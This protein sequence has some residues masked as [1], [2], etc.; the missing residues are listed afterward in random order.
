MRYALLLLF[1]CLVGL[2]LVRAQEYSFISYSLTEGLPQSQVSA[3]VEDDKGYLWVGT[4]GGLARFNGSEFV[5]FSTEDGLK[6]NRITSLNFAEKTLWIG[7]EGG[8]SQYRAGKFKNWNLKKEHK[9]VPVSAVCKWKDMYL[10]TTNGAGLYLLTASG[11]LSW[12]N[13]QTADENRIR[14]ILTHQ[15]KVYLAT[16]GGI[17]KTN[18]LKTFYP[19]TYKQ[20][21]INASSI[22]LNNNKL[23]IG[24]YNF[25]VVYYDFEKNAYSTVQKID[26]ESG[27]RNAVID[28]NGN[29]WAIGFDGLIRVSKRGEIK[30]ITE[31]NGL[32]LNSLSTVY[33]DNTGTIWLGSEGKGLF[34]LTGDKFLSYTINQGIPSE[35]I[36]AIYPIN[37]HE[38]LIGTYDKGL[39]RFDKRN[40]QFSSLGSSEI[41]VW[42]LEKDKAGLFWVG[43]ENGLYTFDAGRNT[44]LACAD[45]SVLNKKISCLYKEDNTIWLATETQLLQLANGKVIKL[46]NGKIDNNEVG[47]IRSMRRYNGKL[48]CGTDGGLF[49]FDSKFSRFIEPIQKVN[50]LEIDPFNCLWIGTENGL[51]SLEKTTLKNIYLSKASSAKSVNFLR[52]AESQL[53]IGTNNGLY[54]ISLQKNREKTEIHHFGIEEGLINLETNL[55][56]ASFDLNTNL[57]FGTP[58]GLVWMRNA[59]QSSKP[60][61]SHPFLAVKSLLIN[62]QEVD[63]SKLKHTLYEDG[64]LASIHLPY[65]KNNLKFDL[66]GV[67]L[68][69]AKK[70][71]F[72]YKLEGLTDDWSPE[73]SNPELNLTNL[74]FGTYTLRIRA[75]SGKN[76]YSNEYVLLLEITPPFYKTW[77]FIVLCILLLGLFIRLVFKFRIRQEKEKSEK[78]KLQFQSRLIALEQQ[79]LN[80]SMN[81]HFI[82]NSLNSIQYFIN[83]QDRISANRY[84]TNFAKLI[85]KNLDSSNETNGMVSLQEEIERLEL[86]LSL[87]SMR[88]KDRFV[89]EIKTNSIDAEQ[90]MVPAMLFQPFVENSII[91]GILPI[92]DRV[93]KISIEL[94]LKD[95]Y[96]EVCIEDNGVGID[97][98]LSKKQRYSG[99]H[100]SQ[101]MEITSKRIE[102]LKQLKQQNYELEGPFQMKE[103]NRLINGTRVLLKIPVENLENQFD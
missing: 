55:N 36:T 81:R 39:I 54:S 22:S 98:S 12:I 83:T 79:S 57:W 46:K 65:T 85:R 8:F 90:I 25:G 34:K 58:E 27:I 84:L 93:G 95:T 74:P 18:D 103:N 80:A 60:G 66:D 28:K 75:K 29:T 16:R 97:T 49:S 99:D 41:T 89:Y 30:Q 61:N 50:S 70:I 31:K 15:G 9:N 45:S 5:N 17:I 96:L 13:L 44:L 1:S 101:G 82:F 63:L 88:F 77:W 19:V 86:Y 24:S 38:L 100:K 68:T 52:L 26:P 2:H 3:L 14:S 72:Q 56:S 10:I 76:V 32:P 94:T 42:T 23:I 48:L 73:F 64:E 47:T 43:T 69:D 35:L 40:Q 20:E 21:I 59:N 91:H 67:S 78:E 37:Q 33:A 51:F 71:S 53:Y 87:E 6:N 92:E 7:H 11:K 4:L 62:F 102:L